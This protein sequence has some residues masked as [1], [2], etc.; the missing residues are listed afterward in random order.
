[1]AARDAIAEA[2]AELL[3]HLPEDGAAVLNADDDFFP[4]LLER[5]PC[6]VVSFG[7]HVGADVMVD[8]VSVTGDGS[9]GFLLRA[10]WGEQRISLSVGGRHHALNA[11]AA[12]AV[13][14]AAGADPAWVAPGLASFSGAEQRSRIVCA[15]GGFTVIDDSYNAAPDSMRVALE[16]LEDV[17]ARRKWAV[18]GDMKELGPMAPEWHREVGEMAAV[19]EASRGWWLWESLDT[20]SRK[21]RCACFLLNRWSR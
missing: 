9:T 6:R 21:G 16:L 7:Q 13:A 2:K 14:V 3:A 10:R 19:F 8:Q 1:M 4:F 15:P 12:A 17:P 18:L 20:T 11:A 5:S